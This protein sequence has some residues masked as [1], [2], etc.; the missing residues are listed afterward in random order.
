MRKLFFIGFLFF[1][2]FNDFFAQCSDGGVC[3]LNNT[4]TSHYTQSNLTFSFNYKF[5]LGSKSEEVKFHSLNL[6]IKYKLF[7]KSRLQIFLPYNSQTGPLG[8]V[9]GIGDA[10]INWNQDLL[11]KED[12]KLEAVI[13]IKLSTGNA[14]KNALPQSYQSGLGSNDLILALDL[15][16]KDWG[17][18]LGYQKA[19]GRNNNPLTR[20]KRGDDFLLRA[21]YSIP[22]DKFTFIPQLVFIKQL[23]RSSIIDL[24]KPNELFFDLPNSDQSQLNFLTQIIYKF[25][26]NY[27]LSIEAAFP[28]IKRKINVDGLTR[29][30]SF[31]TGVRYSI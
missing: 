2:C 3:Q 16:I 29:T 22:L 7:E 23:S 17:I 28:F 27:G 15:F 9:D 31:S 8:S 25:N 18:G 20:L 10:I 19:G 11:H 4:E 12:I 13:G 21:S 26:T 1:F 14:S 30:L 24:T 5:G 6:A